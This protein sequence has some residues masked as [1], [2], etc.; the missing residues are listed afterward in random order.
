MKSILD[1]NY[2]VTMPDGSQWSVPVVVIATNR[3]ASYADEFDG[4]TA[5]SL[6]EDTHPLFE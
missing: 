2:I 4:D 3:A 5:R 6:E 1:K